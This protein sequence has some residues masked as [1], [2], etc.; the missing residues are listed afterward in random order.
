LDENIVAKLNV[1]QILETLEG[2][3]LYGK[4]YLSIGNGL[5][6]A[7]LSV[8]ATAPTFFGLM[9]EG[10]FVMA[11]MCLA[12]L[13]DKHPGTVTISL[14]FEEA[15][16]NPGAFQRADAMQVAKAVREARAKTAKLAGV[17]AAITHRRNTWFAHVDPRA[18]TDPSAHRTKAELTIDQLQH[19]YAETESIIQEFGYLFDRVIGPIRFLGGDDYKH[20]CKLLRKTAGG[21]WRKFDKAFGAQFG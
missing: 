18:V 5:R 20:L 4:T 7:E 6:S 2:Q 10:G 13:Y 21:D 12:R 14:L 19:A 15:I 9:S 8:Q 1:K 17:L 3:F 16:R 11:Q